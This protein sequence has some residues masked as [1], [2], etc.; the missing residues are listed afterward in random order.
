MARGL[1]FLLL[2]C[3]LAAAVWARES[4]AE[5]SEGDLAARVAELERRVAELETRIEALRRR[6]PLA[7]IPADRFPDM[8]P[9][10]IPKDFQGMRYYIMPLWASSEEFNR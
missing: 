7:A 8:P 9:G 5:G 6:A 10:A 4:G 1:L 3:L 2:A